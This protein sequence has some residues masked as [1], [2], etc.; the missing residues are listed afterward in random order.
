MSFNSIRGH[1]K[2]IDILQR[3]IKN[4]RLPGG[5]L[6]C[7]PRGV[8]KATTAVSLASAMHCTAGGDDGCIVC[9]RIRD[10]NFP[11]VEFIDYEWQMNVETKPKPLK[12]KT[13][14]IDAIKELQHRV[15]LKPMEGTWKIFIIDRA[16]TMTTDASNCFL[17]ILEEPPNHTLFILVADNESRILP[18]IRSRCQI[19]RFGYLNRKDFSSVM[20]KSGLTHPDLYEITDGAPGV[21]VEYG[22]ENLEDMENIM[23]LWQKMLHGDLV[24]VLSTAQ[25]EYNSREEI[26]YLF[27]QLLF[28]A[29]KRLRNQ[30]GKWDSTVVRIMQALTHIRKNIN[31]RLVRDVTLINLTRGNNA[32]SCWNCSAENEG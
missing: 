20:K 27:E 32:D 3:Q 29:K 1:R 16:D 31:A 12:R 25:R 10:K 7:G 8:G 14:G 6:F 18:T 21:G 30:C 4:G 15:S 13:I 19:V 28:P 26:E 24:E 5:Y 23:L 11:D 22:A 9:K 17:K 2:A